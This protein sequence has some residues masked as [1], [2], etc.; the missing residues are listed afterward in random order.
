MPRPQGIPPGRVAWLLAFV[1]A[2]GVILAS[3]AQAA[4][5]WDANE[6]GH[7]L[8]I[9]WVGVY[10]QSDGRMRVTVTFYDRV[11][12]SWFKEAGSW[13]ALSVGF[14]DDPQIRPY[15]F[16]DAFVR[17]HRL[18]ARLCESGSAC[19]VSGVSRPNGATLRTRIGFD[20][21]RGPHSGWRF[22]ATS[23]RT[24]SEPPRIIDKTAWGKVT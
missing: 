5:V 9:R 12:L 24:T 15:F 23:A 16:L 22:R 19:V 10:E 4:S 21:G 1:V 17:N 13:H 6:P 11:R 20:D 14:T 8:D 3:P 7:R 2:C 18:K